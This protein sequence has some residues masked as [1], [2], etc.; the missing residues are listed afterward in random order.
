MKTLP[1][2]L[3]SFATLGVAWMYFDHRSTVIE[4]ADADALVAAEQL[5]RLARLD[6]TFETMADRF[7]AIESRLGRLEDGPRLERDAVPATPQDEDATAPAREPVAKEADGAAGSR[8]LDDLLL[9][10]LDP[11][12]GHANSEELWKEITEKGL[13]DSAIAKLKER[14]EMDPN[15]PDLQVDLAA[16]YLRKLFSSKNPLEQG[17]WAMKMDVCYDQALG[18]DPKHWDARFSKAI[19][20]SFWPAITGKPQESVKQFE[21]LRDQQEALGDRKPQYAETYVMLGNLYK[22]QGKTDLAKQ[23]YEKG[24]SFFPEHGTLKTQIDSL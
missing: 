24:L 23:T 7:D 15:N 17:G 4:R 12:T 10:L 14:A 21:I 8:E 13:L 1:L 11:Q 9:K 16:G 5:E 3:G 20:Y 18:V 2:L 6:T 19:S 22:Q